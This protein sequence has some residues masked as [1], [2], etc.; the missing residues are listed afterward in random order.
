MEYWVLFSMQQQHWGIGNNLK[1][2]KKKKIF[3]GEDSVSSVFSIN[4]AND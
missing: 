1:N 4:E 3:Y 2:L